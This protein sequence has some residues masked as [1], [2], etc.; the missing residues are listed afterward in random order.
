MPQANH[1]DK[2]ILQ[3]LKQLPEVTD[4]R[5]KEEI[6]RNM[7]RAIQEK[8]KK[9]KRRVLIPTLSSIAVLL[10]FILVSPVLLG[11][12]PFERSAN[13]Q[14]ESQLADHQPESSSSQ[15]RRS[16]QPEEKSDADTMQANEVRKQT[17]S[18]KTAVYSEDL[19][20]DEVF[21]YGSL[22]NDEGLIPVSVSLLVPKH[23]DESSWLE[24]YKEAAKEMQEKS[25]GLINID[26]LLD[27]VVIEDT[28]TARVI[29]DKDFRKNFHYQDGLDDFIQ[30]LFQYTDID[31]VSFTDENGQPV[32]FGNSGIKQDQTI[33][34]Q[35]HKAQ[36]LYETSNGEP[37]IVAD[38]TSSENLDEAIQRM[39]KAPD[40]FRQSLIPN[41]IQPEVVQ[42]DNEM[43]TVQFEQPLNLVEGDQQENMW[44]IEGIL[45][46]AK[47]F[48]FQSVQFDN[49]ESEHWQG[50]RFDQPIQIPVAPNVL[51]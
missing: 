27:S 5:S 44:M 15:V 7:K 31:Y 20:K 43:V 14:E 50:F 39:K 51:R 23:E 17:R 22:T 9:S 26:P 6:Y 1:H 46:A 36:F 33:E 42:E 10:I 40:G 18:L 41:G 35:Q 4:H 47:D 19:K 28:T 2:K 11:P 13:K 37:F 12:F 49:I 29:M 8:P 34:K 38:H 32:E 24:Q 3:L 48:G 21:T 45:L 30:S 16:A 25:T